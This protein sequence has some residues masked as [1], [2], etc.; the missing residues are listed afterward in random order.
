MMIEPNHSTLSIRRQCALIGLNRATWYAEPQ[1][2]NTFN[3]HLM[4]VIDEQY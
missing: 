3:L 2:E 4:R 1:G